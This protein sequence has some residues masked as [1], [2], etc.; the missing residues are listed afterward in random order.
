M[1]NSIELYEEMEKNYNEICSAA[2]IKIYTRTKEINSTV[3]PLSGFDRKNP[4]HLF[5]LGAARGLSG[6]L[7]SQVAVDVSE[8]HRKVMNKKIKVDGSKLAPYLKEYK[9]NSANVDNIL[10]ELREWARGKC[11]E[12]FT[13]ADIYYEFY[14]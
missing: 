12:E 14:E 3:I 10:N 8:W 13:F 6:V 5:V 9:E 11:G 7:G 2:M 4:E 1:K